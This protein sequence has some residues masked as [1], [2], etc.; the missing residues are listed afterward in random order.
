MLF[1]VSA[2][3]GY[4]LLAVCVGTVEHKINRHAEPPPG[5]LLSAG[6]AQ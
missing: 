5:V 4:V 6:C 3:R 2:T 1:S